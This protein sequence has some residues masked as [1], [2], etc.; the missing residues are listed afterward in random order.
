MPDRFEGPV[1]QPTCRLGP[2]CR[3]EEATS[4]LDTP[5]RPPTVDELP[6]GPPPAEAEPFPQP[7]DRFLHFEL[8][9]E[10]GRGAFA[11]V[12]LAKQ[13]SLAHRLVVLKLTTTPTDEPQKLARLQHTNVVP[14]YSV[15]D[16]GRFHAL[17]M[18]F[19]GRVTLARAIAHLTARTGKPPAT[20]RDLLGTVLGG[21]AV[22]GT[23]PV[24]SSLALSETR[25]ALGHMSFVEGSLWFAAQLAAG[26][27]HAHA[28]HILHRDLKPANVLVTVDGVPM[29]LDFNVSSESARATYDGRI[30]GTLPYMAPEHLRAFAGEDTIVDERSDLYSLGVI[31]YELLTGHLPHSTPVAASREA[32]L[33]EMIAQRRHPPVPPSTSNPAVTPAVD[34]LVLKLLDPVP[35]L[36]YDRAEHLREDLTCQLAHRPLKFAADRSFREWGR[37]WRRRNPRLATGLA[38]AAFALLFLLLPAGLIAA[39]ESEIAA[40]AQQVQRSEAEAGYAIA[41]QELRTAAVLLGSRSDPALREQ[42]LALANAVLD[43]YGVPADPAWES[44]RGFALLDPEKRAALK[45]ELGEVL[46]LMTRAE[47]QKGGAPDAAPRW[48]ALAAQMFVDADRPAAIARQREELVARQVGRPVE[49]VAVPNPETAR[50]ADLYFDGLDLAATDRHAEALPLL[51][52]YC[53]KEPTRFLAW[54]ARGVCHDA[55]NQPAD[56]VAAFAVCVALRPDSPFARADRGLAR[57]KL[58]R[59]AEAEADFTAALAL[60]PGAALTRITL[61]NRGLAREGQRKFREAEADFTAALDEPNAPTRLYFLRSRVRRLAGDATGADADRAEGLAKDPAD[62]LS[63]GTRGSWHLAARQYEAALADFDAALK[64]NPH[65][66]DALLNKAV[67][68]ADHL[69]READAIP[70][71]DRLLELAPDYVDAR[72]SRGVYLARLGRADEARRDAADALKADRGAYR[73]FQVAGLFA[74]LSKRDPKAKD[75]ALRYLARALRAGF[76]DAN[77]LKTDPDLDPIRDD[78]GFVRLVAT[79]GELDRLGR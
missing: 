22:S 75:E 65:S 76:A 53:E 32:A 77:L 40:R 33:A 8:V 49:A 36:R 64:L 26:L 38:V 4:R 30:G 24:A 69:H 35:I 79:A 25:E 42:G 46:I 16:A 9:E 61:L 41:M 23:A 28:R 56:A 37:K 18:P 7:G 10:L 12:Y 13:E 59:Y 44:Q 6:P 63:W 47:A 31:L 43:R 27:A 55:L 5:V 14:V 1:S 67:V 52:R 51:A 45:A 48:N 66:R 20:G 70:L 60:K 19:L 73:Q 15:H 58:R 3:E 71:L 54:F 34:A 2:P 78:P 17:C 57:L 11:R 50:N 62:A 72:C 68:L 21:L 29:I 39:R 74:Q